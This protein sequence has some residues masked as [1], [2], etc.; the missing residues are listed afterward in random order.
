MACVLTKRTSVKRK[1]HRGMS[2]GGS[3]EGTVYRPRRNHLDLR[4]LA[5]DSE[6]RVLLLKLL[7]S[8]V[9]VRPPQETHTRPAASRPSPCAG[10]GTFLLTPGGFL[11]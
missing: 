4:L 3:G 2:T 11:L 10:P 5:P 8:V 6:T 7:L 9:L 1:M